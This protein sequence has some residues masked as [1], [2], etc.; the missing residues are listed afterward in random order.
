MTLAY[1]ADRYFFYS[2]RFSRVR[3]GV[4]NALAD[5]PTI[6]ETSETQLHE[7]TFVLPFFTSID[8]YVG[9]VLLL[10]GSAHLSEKTC[11]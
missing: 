9:C 4:S 11:P 1:L 3:T 10:E 5:A 7:S 2:L 6:P 8:F